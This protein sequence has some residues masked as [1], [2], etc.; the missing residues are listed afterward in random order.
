MRALADELG[1][2]GANA[3][4]VAA[5]RRNI[6]VTRAQVDA[7]VKGRDEKQVLGAPQRAAGKTVSEDDNRWMMDLIDTVN[8]PYAGCKFILFCVNA[9]DRYIYA[10]A[11]KSKTGHAVANALKSILASAEKKPQVISSDN[12]TEFTQGPVVALLG[13]E[14]IIQKFKDPKDLNALGLADRNIGILKRKL[15]ELHN[16]NNLT[17]ATNLERA[18]KQ[19]NATPKPGVLYGAAPKDVQ[20]EP[21]VEFMLLRDQAQAIA[22]NQR[23]HDK[24]KEALLDTGTFR[25]P[26][27]LTKFK[28]RNFQATY[29]DP[30][31]VDA[32]SMGRVKATNGQEFPLKQIK[33][34]PATAKRVGVRAAPRR[35]GDAAPVRRAR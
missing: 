1:Q 35:L 19:V 7:L 32:V 8:I 33:I 26:V 2:P 23:L 5:R 30:L 29:G 18:V 17:W 14:G 16:Q 4:W 22:H 25:A 6:N 12:G 15:G 27:A 34:V 11:L 31:E 24:K 13:A 21:E 10:R 28:K 20:N 3:L 9:F